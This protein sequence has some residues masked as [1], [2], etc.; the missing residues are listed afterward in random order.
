MRKI[1]EDWEPLVVCGHGFGGEA[2]ELAGEVG[3]VGL[4]SDG[5]LADVDAR[6]SV[7]VEEREDLAAEIGAGEHCGRFILHLQ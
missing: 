2:G 7:D 4:E 1:A 6:G 3:G 5:Q